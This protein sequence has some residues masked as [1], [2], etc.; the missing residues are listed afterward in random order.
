MPPGLVSPRFSIFERRLAEGHPYPVTVNCLLTQAQSRLRSEIA[1]L[2]FCLPFLSLAS[3]LA[4]HPKTSTTY[5]RCDRWPLALRRRHR[6]NITDAE[7][8]YYCLLDVK[9][10]L[11]FSRPRTQGSTLYITGARH[12]GPCDEQVFSPFFPYQIR[13]A[14]ARRMTISTESEAS[15]SGMTL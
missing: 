9:A 12:I 13:L 3:A 10:Q 11:Q 6:G 1:A 14:T 7:R 5:W 2:L 8:L 4:G 15:E